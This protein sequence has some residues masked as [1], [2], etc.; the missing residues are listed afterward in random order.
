MTTRLVVSLLSAGEFLDRGLASAPIPNAEAV[1]RCPIVV[2]GRIVD[3][4]MGAERLSLAC[5]ARGGLRWG[6]PRL[7]GVATGRLLS[8]DGVIGCDGGRRMLNP[9]ITLYERGDGE[10]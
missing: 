6:R 9:L 2:A 1:W 8:A 3:A 7:W 10:C 5:R 4:L